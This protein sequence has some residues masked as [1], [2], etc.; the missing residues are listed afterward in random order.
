MKPNLR[1]L[2]GEAINRWYPGSYPENNRFG[3][4][5]RSSDVPQVFSLISCA[6]D[7]EASILLVSDA[8]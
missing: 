8:S 2:S 4:E 1:G 6:P 3:A 5:R 7:F